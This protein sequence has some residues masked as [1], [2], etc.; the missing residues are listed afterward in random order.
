MTRTQDPGRVNLLISATSL[1]DQ[2]I[3]ANPSS[4]PGVGREF[5]WVVSKRIQSKAQNCFG[6]AGP[7]ARPST[8]G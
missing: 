3:S 8:H 5:Q 7:Q 4:W 2:D 1:K 6:G